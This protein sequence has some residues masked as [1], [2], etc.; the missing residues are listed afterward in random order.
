MSDGPRFIGWDMGA[1]EGDQTIYT[2][3][4]R[5]SGQMHVVYAGPDGQYAESLA[6]QLCARPRPNLTVIEGDLSS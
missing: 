5:R 3:S 4:R 6:K 1:P 2:V